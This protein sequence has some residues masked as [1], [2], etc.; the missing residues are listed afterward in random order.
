MN[1]PQPVAQTRPEGLLS[2]IRAGF[3]ESERTFTPVADLIRLTKLGWQIFTSFGQALLTGRF[4]IGELIIQCWYTIRVCSLPALAVAIPFGVVLALQV[5]LLSQQVGAVAFTGA[6]NTLA[7]IRQAAPLVTALI[8]AG[9]AGSSICA[10]LGARKIREELD[11][12]EVMGIPVVQRLV[13]PRAI[14]TT[15]MGMLITGLVMF[16]TIVT[17]LLVSSVVMS[18]PPGTYLASVSALAHPSDMALSMFKAAVFAIITTTVAADRG[19]RVRTGPAGVGDAV[20]SAVV[21]NFVLL[22]AVNVLIS[23]IASMFSSGPLG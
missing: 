7:V 21:T 4:P 11:A 18:L 6:G 8:L 1:T 17:T 14:A 23:Q 3:S 2:G 19:V 9:V 22:F 20:T 10:D 5:G 13:M 12:M 16:F 15:I